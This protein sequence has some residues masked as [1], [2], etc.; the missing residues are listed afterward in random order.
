MEHSLSK[1]ERVIPVQGIYNV[2]VIIVWGINILC[3]GIHILRTWL[4]LKVKIVNQ[5]QPNLS[6]LSPRYTYILTLGIHVY[7]LYT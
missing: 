7:T 3:T 4:V 1:S 6:Q 2:L 5:N